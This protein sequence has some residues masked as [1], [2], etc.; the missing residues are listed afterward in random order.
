MLVGGVGVLDWIAGY[1]FIVDAM[2]FEKAT[3]FLGSFILRTDRAFLMMRGVDLF[4][5]FV[6]FGIF[7]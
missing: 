7:L 4:N 1:C 5:F 3:F 2:V 6:H